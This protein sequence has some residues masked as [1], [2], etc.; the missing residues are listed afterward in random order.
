M[1]YYGAIKRSKVDMKDHQDIVWNIE[2]KGTM[3]NHSL[4]SF[5][6]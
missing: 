5:Y 4:T 6:V 3:Q 1:K 2:T